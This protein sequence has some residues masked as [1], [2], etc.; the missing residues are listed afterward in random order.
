MAVNFPNAGEMNIIRFI[1]PAFGKLTA[2]EQ[3]LE[4]E[5]RSQHSDLLNYSEEIAFFNGASWE[6]NRINDETFKKLYKHKSGIIKKKFWMGIFDSMLTKYGAVLMGYTVLGLPVFGSNSEA[7]VEAQS[8]DVGA[9]TRD[10]VRNSS[11]L[12]NLSKAI[13]KIV[14]SYKELQNLAAYTCLLYTS[15]AADE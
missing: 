8:A 6:K 7:Y 1:S 3:N 15:D 14:I 9:I 10:Y 11:M 5:Y 4:G 13:G 12:I 2:M